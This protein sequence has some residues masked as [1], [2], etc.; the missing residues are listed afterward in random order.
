MPSRP[1]EG[2]NSQ[3][4]SSGDNLRA[5]SGGGSSGARLQ[6]AADAVEAEALAILMGAQLHSVWV[7]IIQ[8]ED[9]KFG[10]RLGAALG[11]R[12]RA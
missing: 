7:D 2:S 8:L 4:A 11:S 10:R 12:V 1:Q 6:T 3:D 9:L 5:L